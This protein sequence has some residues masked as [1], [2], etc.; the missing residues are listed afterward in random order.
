M[1]KI[2]VTGRRWL[3]SFHILFSCIWIGAGI[4]LVFM[5]YALHP[6]DGI[7]LYGIDSSMKFIDDYIII[8]G[9][10]GCLLTGFLI[11]LLTPWGFFRYRWVT[12]KWI[13]TFAGIIFGTFWLGPWLNSLP[14]ISFKEG[15]DALSNT[16]YIHAR[17]MNSFYAPFQVLTLIF[18]VFISVFKPWGKRKK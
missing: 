8:P 16:E 5:Q 15:I 6:S 11:S 10:L 13:I 2:G 3:V 4:C 1:K 9:A 14:P 17:E 12:V 18:A 7:G